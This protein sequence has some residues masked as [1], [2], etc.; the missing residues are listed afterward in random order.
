MEYIFLDM[1]GFKDNINEFVLKEIYILSKNLRF[2]DIVKSYLEFSSLEKFQQLESIWLTKNY[3]GL[4]WNS[5]YISIDQARATMEPIV[6]G[7]IVLL[8]G[9]EK[10][11]WLKTIIPNSSY[12]CINIEDLGCNIKISNVF[13]TRKICKKHNSEYSKFHCAK[14]N[15]WCIK[16]WFEKSNFNKKY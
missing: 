1:Q 14:E 10:I 16:K 11:K 9:V 6:D 2:H 4:D 7:K 12:F 15:V 5:G 3:H 13:A 8:K